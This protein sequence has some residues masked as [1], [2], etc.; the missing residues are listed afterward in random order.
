VTLSTSIPSTYSYV[1]QRGV[2]VL[3]AFGCAAWVV[4]WLFAPGSILA[5]SGSLIA[6]AILVLVP[7]RRAR[8][9]VLKLESESFSV[10]SGFLRL[11]PRRIAYTSIRD[12]REHFLPF[13]VAVLRISAGYTTVEI[14]SAFLQDSRQYS[15]LRTF[16]LE[17]QWITFGSAA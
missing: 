16:F 17:R 10:P 15:A 11:L 14:V 9:T 4:L 5:A 7:A 12:V 3:L 2:A 8:L 6:G 1:P 13:N